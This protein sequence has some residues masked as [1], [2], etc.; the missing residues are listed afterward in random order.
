[1]RCARPGTRV[2][3]RAV[4][5]RGELGRRGEAL[6]AEALPARAGSRSWSATSA[7]ARARSTWSPWTARRSCSS[8]CAAG[9][10]PSSGTPLES[11]DGRKQA[12]VARVARHFLA[13]RGHRERDVRFDVVGIRFDA[14][15]PVVEHVRGRLRR[16]RLGRLGR[17]DARHPSDPRRTRPGEGRAGQGGRGGRRR[18]TPCS[19]PIGGVARS[20]HA[21]ETLRAERTAASKAIGD[22]EGSGGARAGHRRT[23]R[24]WASASRRPKTAVAAAEAAF[25]APM[26]ELPNLPHPDVPVGPGRDGERRRAH[27]GRAARLR[28]RRR[29]R[30]GTSGRALGI[31]DFER[32]VKISGSRFY[33]LRGMGARLQRALITW[34]LDLHTREHGYIEVYP[35]AMVSGECLVGTGQLP[36][37]RRHHVP[38]HRGGL[39]VG[40]HRRGA[41]HQPLPRRDPRRRARCRSA[42]SPTRRASGAR[43]CRPAATCAASSAATSS[44]R[45]RW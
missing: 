10:A 14:E 15:P 45:S 25:R 43:R 21:V 9:A 12:R 40:A 26:L 16:G 31:I 37:V 27:G 42:T 23:A 20:I 35:P 36:E 17:N 4:D 5:G 19:R 34:M 33:V 28:L 44:T 32:G 13:A 6:A 3:S 22:A 29:C 30:T 1:M 7:A 11:V 24:A 39:L 8:R 38:R 41:G 2:L 18:S